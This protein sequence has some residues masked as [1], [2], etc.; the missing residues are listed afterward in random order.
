MDF[1]KLVGQQQ[2]ELA[3]WSRSARGAANLLIDGFSHG[4]PVRKQLMVA[5]ASVPHWEPH[6][7]L[8]WLYGEGACVAKFVAVPVRSEL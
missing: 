6:W 3:A 7:E 2:P 8:S 4:L 5:L 1:S